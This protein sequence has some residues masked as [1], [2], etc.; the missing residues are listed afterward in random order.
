MTAERNNFWP[1]V[2]LS[3]KPVLKELICFQKYL[4]VS[5]VSSTKLMKIMA[6][7]IFIKY[8]VIVVI[9]WPF[10][11]ERERVCYV[12]LIVYFSSILPRKQYFV[13]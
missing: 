6:N 9:T 13:P 12:A 10:F 7:F 3:N 1:K 8:A 11:K 4:V 5:N 2:P